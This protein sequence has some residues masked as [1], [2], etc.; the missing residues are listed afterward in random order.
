MTS[1]SA[2]TPDAAIVLRAVEAMNTGDAEGLL[3]VVDPEADVDLGTARPRRDELAQAVDYELDHLIRHIEVDELID[4][5]GGQV[6]VAFRLRYLWKEGGEVA[7]EEP[8]AM[9]VTVRDGRIVRSR[10]HPD[11]ASALAAAEV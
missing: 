6:V 7:D 11:R 4:V 2:E 8:G 1:G 5:G 9:L 3:A 10:P